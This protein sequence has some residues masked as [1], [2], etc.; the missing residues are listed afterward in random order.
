MHLIV[1][2]AQLDTA[3][4]QEALDRAAG[5]LRAGGLVALP[6]ETVYGLGANALDRTAVERIFAAKSRPAWDP[7]IVHIAS[8]AMLEGLVE[9][10]PAEARRLMDAFWPGPLTLLLPRAAAVPDAV[11][12]GRPLVGVRMPSHPVA[13]ELIRR[14]QVPVAAPSA[15]R[16][17]HISP[18]TAQHVLDDL[19][20]R[21]DAV[22]DAGPATRGVESTVLDPATTPMTIYRPGAV[23]AEQIRA[24]AGP[25]E[26]YRSGEALRETPAEALPSPG[27]GIRHYAPRARLVLVEAAL[28]ELAA[29]LESAARSETSE[30]VGVMLPDGVT[31]P[32]AIAEDRVFLWGRWNAPE[33]LAQRL[34]AGLRALDAAGC[35]V[36]LC[37]LPAAEGIGAA[38]RDRLKKAGTI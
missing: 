8:V 18:T 9:E 11:T 14:A 37:P 15:N 22:V 16:F 19:D 13:L 12:A 5:I 20:G 2:P 32:A 34:Y 1:D 35:T 31:A 38:I 10:V 27:V 17:G 30:R 28:A 4:A 26:M 7:I 23:T 3:A 6:T 29:C 36:I 25:V 33:E 21:I 24:V